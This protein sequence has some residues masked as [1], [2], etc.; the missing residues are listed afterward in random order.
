[1]EKPVHI[2]NLISEAGDLL[3][4]QVFFEF[5]KNFFSDSLLDVNRVDLDSGGIILGDFLDFNTSFGGGHD[6]GALTVPVEDEGEVDLAVNVDTL[7]DQHSVDLEPILSGLVGDQVVADHLLSF[8]L[9]LLGSLEDLHTSLEATRESSYVKG[10]IPFP[11]PP[12]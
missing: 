6:G 7:V 8:F 2:L 11:L 10:K 1:M 12:A 3:K 4:L 9:D 5:V